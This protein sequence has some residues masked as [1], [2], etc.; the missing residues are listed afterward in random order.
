MS[1][2]LLVLSK[3]VQ[4]FINKWFCFKCSQLP[5]SSCRLFNCEEKPFW[6]KCINGKPLGG[7]Q[8]IPW[9]CTTCVDHCYQERARECSG[10]VVCHFYSGATNR[11][12]VMKR[13]SIPA[14]VFTKRASEKKKS[15]RRLE[16]SDLQASA[17][18]K[19][20]WQ[21]MQLLRTHWEE[22]LREAEGITYEARGF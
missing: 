13:L 18:E 11:V 14:G 16:K 2:H 5:L 20:C 15:E 22:A 1:N 19:K 9:C 8:C 17:K 7:L 3:E 4:M 12:R 6:E 10:P 21:G